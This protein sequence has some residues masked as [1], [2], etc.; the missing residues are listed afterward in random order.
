MVWHPSI[1][2]SR[3]HT[4]HDSPWGSMRH[5]QHTFLPDSKEDRCT[6]MHE[7][8]KYM[9]LHLKPADLYTS[10]SY[11][12]SLWAKIKV[13]SAVWTCSIDLKPNTILRPYQEK[14]LRKMFG[15]GRARSGVIVLPCGLLFLF[16]FLFYLCQTPLRLMCVQSW[17]GSADVTCSVVCVSVCLSVYWSHKCSVHKRLNLSRCCLGERLTWL[18]GT[19]Y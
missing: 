12:Y 10:M 6:C 9:F 18:Q 15:N 2:L 4:H 7:C 13:T 8:S 3:W 14:S 5:G 11:H 17:K 1:C 19:M 16:L